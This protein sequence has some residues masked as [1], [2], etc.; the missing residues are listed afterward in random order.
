MIRIVVQLAMHPKSKWSCHSEQSGPDRAARSSSR[1]ARRDLPSAKHFSYIK[2]VFGLVSCERRN[3]VQP[4]I[5]YNK[6]SHIYISFQIVS[7]REG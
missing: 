2:L 3:A 6:V 1:S 5:I 7:D 4:K